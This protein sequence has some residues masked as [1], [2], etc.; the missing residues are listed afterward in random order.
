[1]TLIIVIGCLFLLVIIEGLFIL[2]D[3]IPKRKNHNGRRS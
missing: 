2:S 3:K 1:M